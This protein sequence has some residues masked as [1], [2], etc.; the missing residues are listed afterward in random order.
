DSTKFIVNIYDDNFVSSYAQFNDSFELY[1]YSEFRDIIVTPEDP[2]RGNMLNI[3]STLTTEFG[4][5]LASRNVTFQ[6]ND[7]GEW[8][9]ISSQ[10]TDINGS[11]LFE[12][13]TLTLNDDETLLFR[14]IWPGDQYFLNIPY[15]ISV[16]LLGNVI[17][18]SISLQ[19]KQVQ[20]Y[21]NT[22]TTFIVNLENLGLYDVR[23]SNI[24]IDINPNLPCEVVEINYLLLNQFS[25]GYTTTFII[26]VDVSSITQFIV[27]VSA[28]VQNLLTEEVIIIHTSETFE[29]FEKPLLDYMNDYFILIIFTIFGILALVTFLF[30]KKTKKSI[31]TPIE[32]PSKKRARRGQYLSV[33]EIP[34]KT[35]EA[36]K[37][38]LPSN[39]KANKK[40][41]KKKLKETESENKKSTDLDSLLEEKGLKDDDK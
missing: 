14:L 32:E 26:E 40:I 31:E 36:E 4:T 7:I 2:I 25:S 5:E 11:T 16:D 22:K 20:I 6:Y 41:T 38:Q 8:I 3:S 12:I 35:V 17:N 15:N 23:I 34:T 10:F 13:D 18:V 37:E 1:M 9:N 27:S 29:T 24:T 39:K 28:D 21:R 19:E 33:S 30:V